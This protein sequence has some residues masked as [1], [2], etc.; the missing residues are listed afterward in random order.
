[1][2]Q[3]GPSAISAVRSGRI[4]GSRRTRLIGVA[5]YQPWGHNDSSLPERRSFWPAKSPLE[6]VTFEAEREARLCNRA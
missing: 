2:P 3:F 1:M 6:Q 5:I 4:K